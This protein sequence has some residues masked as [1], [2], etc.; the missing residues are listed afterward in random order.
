M[1][2]FSS[3]GY[4]NFFSAE[5]YAVLINRLDSGSDQ[6]RVVL[7]VIDLLQRGLGQLFQLL[8]TAFFLGFQLDQ[9]ARKSFWIGFS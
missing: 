1:A 3:N 6:F 4:L 2:L 5:G 9:N 8:V 7:L